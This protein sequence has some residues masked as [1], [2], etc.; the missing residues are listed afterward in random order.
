MSIEEAILGL[1]AGRIDEESWPEVGIRFI[2]MEAD[3][4]HCVYKEQHYHFKVSLTPV[5]R[6]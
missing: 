4:I 1:I 6:K 3:I 5:E 2:E